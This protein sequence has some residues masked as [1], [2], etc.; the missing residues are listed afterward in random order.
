MNKKKLMSK[1]IETNPDDVV[2]FGDKSW[3]DLSIE[4]NGKLFLCKFFKIPSGCQITV[5]NR[6]I[7]QI[8]KGKPGFK[9][10]SGVS[11]F[12][13]GKDSRE[14]VKL[15]ILVNNTSQVRKWINECEMEFVNSYT[16]I[17]GARMCEIEKLPVQIEALG[18][19]MD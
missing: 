8:L 15:A 3:Y 16:D 19:K 13:D 10:I 6:Y 14:H 9:T 12:I 18:Q 4:H 2:N 11:K 17:F 5:N 7:W 1:F